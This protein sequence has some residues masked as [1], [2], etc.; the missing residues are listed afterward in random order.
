MKYNRN[1]FNLLLERMSNR[2]SYDESIELKNKQM[3]IKGYS[4]KFEGG[5]YWWNYDLPKGWSKYINKT[6]QEI[7]FFQWFIANKHILN[8]ISKNKKKHIKIKF[9]NIIDTPH[10]VDTFKKITNF[11]GLKNNYNVQLNNLPLVQITSK[12]KNFK[13]KEKEKEILPLIK[14][15]NILKFI[16]KIGYDISKLDRWL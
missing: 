15:K 8:Y 11:I 13:W 1:Q 4:D 16:K 7:C 10:R 6:L 9:E 5:K 12:P 14:R 3:N 2:Y